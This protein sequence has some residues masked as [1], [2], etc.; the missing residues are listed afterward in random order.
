MLT[1]NGQI[2]AKIEAVEGTEESLAAGDYSGNR[3]EQSHRDQHQAY[4]RDLQ[5]GT[6]TQLPDLP[7]MYTGSISWTEEMVTGDPTAPPWHNTIR[8]QGFKRTNASAYTPTVAAGTFRVGQVVG[9]TIT[10]GAATKVGRVTAILDSGALVIFRTLGADWT[11]AEDCYA[12][13]GATTQAHATL[14]AG[15]PSSYVLTPLTET[16]SS[17]PPSLTVNRILG[18]QR[19]TRIGARGT[20]G[21]TAKMGEPLLL[22]AEFHGVPVYADAV[23]RSPRLASYVTNVP[24]LATPPAVVQSI[25]F[26]LRKDA[27]TTYTPILTELSLQFGNTL[28]PR[29]TISNVDI[30]SSGYLPTRITG[31]NITAS[32]DPEHVLPAAGFDFIG[33]LNAGTAFELQIEVGKSS[34]PNGKIT[35]YAPSVQLNGDYEPGDRDGVATDP[36]TLGFFGNND[37]EIF[38]THSFNTLS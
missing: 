2:G 33:S 28:A 17:V 30:Q 14:A 1:R 3:K 9:N 35:I 31:R 10:L 29:G 34:S 15:V 7:S 12:Y 27:N 23:A 19:H 36:L 25:P 18:G 11:A 8:G 5:R 20:G 6:L 13:D 24:A 22:Q 26:I 32:I 4:K 38:I 21:I 37:D 16:D